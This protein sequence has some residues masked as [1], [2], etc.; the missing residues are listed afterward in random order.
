MSRGKRYDGEQKLNLKK[1][2][3]VII[4]IAVIIMFFIGISKLFN[5][6]SNTQEKTVSMGYFPVYTNGKWGVIDT[7]GE[8]VITPEYDEYIVVP[9]SAEAIFICTTNVDYDKGTYSTKVLN[10]KNEELYTEYDLVE[11]IEN[12]DSSNNLWY[13]KDIL[14]VS[15]DGKWG[16]ID[17]K[18]NII[19]D[20]TYDDIT[21]LKGV[22]NSLLTEVDGKYGIV[23]YVGSVIIENKY[24]SIEPLADKYE[25]GYIVENSE[26]KYGVI[27]YTKNAVLQEKYDAIKNIYG[28]GK[29]YIAKEGDKWEI[30]DENGEK[31]L[32][33]EYSDI[34][35]VNGENAIVSTK[36]KF[37]VVSIA[38]NKKIIDINYDSIVYSSGDKYIVSTDSKYGVIDSNGNVLIKPSYTN[39][40]YRDTAGF[41]EA[42]T[43]NNTSDLL[44]SDL[45]VKLS[46]V[47]ISELNT[48]NGYIKVRQNGEYKYYNFKFEEKTSKEILSGNTIFLSKNE[49]GKYGFVDRNGNVVTDYIY[50]DATEQNE[51]GYAS[52]KKDGLWGSI[53]SRGQIA[54][55]PSYELDNN[56][57]VEFIGKWHL[58]EDLN[59]YYFTDE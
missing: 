6:E 3:A 51:Y 5:T 48:S 45:K 10:E 43:E 29:Y 31:Y 19:V 20:C 1:V 18:G 59:L 41:Y 30:I 14:K 17:T 50:D 28:N 49:E 23:D 35:D 27:T 54:I 12:Y 55:A 11:A 21:A 7:K 8:I 57:L 2:F 13:A 24:K 26:G 58:G 34:L 40:V 38:D 4:A 32:S 36:D 33:G 44:D 46:D 37:G 16:I 56:I 25:K 9:N 53:N 15:K 42:T 39:I 47:I 52:V 22:E